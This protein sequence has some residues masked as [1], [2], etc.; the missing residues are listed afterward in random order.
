ME[1][2]PHNQPHRQHPK[3]SLSQHFLKDTRVLQ[4]IIKYAEIEPADI[5]LEIGGGTGILTEALCQTGARVISIEKDRN[6]LSAHLKPLQKKYKNLELIEGDALEIDL[7]ECTKVVSNLPYCISSALTFKLLDH[8]F[9][10]GILMYQREFAERMCAKP[11]TKEYSKLSINVYVRATCKI[12]EIVPRGAFYPVPEVESAIVHLVP[13]KK[14]PF[15][16]SK[17]EIFYKLVDVAFQHRR[18]KIG[19]IIT[20][21]WENAS[22]ETIAFLRNSNYYDLRP[23]RLSPEDFGRI[24]DV[25][26][27]SSSH[28]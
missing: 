22:T 16:I 2:I 10:D 23:E 4:R 1:K 18:K 8:V 3:K 14:P 9:R 11:D 13:R 17:P 26:A 12:L 5:V 21:H 6:L 27:H 15:N 25:L 20:K 24:A 19:T 7:P 28:A